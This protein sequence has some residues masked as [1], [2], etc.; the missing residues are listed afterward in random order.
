MPEKSEEPKNSG[1][2]VCLADLHCTS[3]E[4]TDMSLPQNPLQRD[5]TMRPTPH[6][7]GVKL[8]NASGLTSEQHDWLPLHFATVELPKHELAWRFLRQRMLRTN[9]VGKVKS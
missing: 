3:D 8:A 6:K 5:R 2:A 7:G 4:L 9:S 1:A